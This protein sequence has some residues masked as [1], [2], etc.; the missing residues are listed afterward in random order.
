MAFGA[1]VDELTARRRAGSGPDALTRL[2]VMPE[3]IS[4]RTNVTNFTLYPLILTWPTSNLTNHYNHHKLSICITVV[5]ICSSWFPSASTLWCLKE[6]LIRGSKKMYQQNLCEPLGVAPMT[7]H[8]IKPCSALP[9]WTP[10]TSICA[11][12]RTAA[13]FQ[14]L[15]IKLPSSIH[16]LLLQANLLSN[17]GKAP[18]ISP[19]HA[20]ISAPPRSRSR[21]FLTSIFGGSCTYT[22]L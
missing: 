3:E 5:W 12:S 20:K 9:L 4:G 11:Y 22:S 19:F 18:V 7:V 6:F 2:F 8:I 13:M 10:F 1:V 16:D 21:T 17:V 14:D 15:P